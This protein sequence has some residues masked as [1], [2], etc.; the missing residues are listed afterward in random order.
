MPLIARSLYTDLHFSSSVS[1]YQVIQGK[2]SFIH[3]LPSSERASQADGINFS[4]GVTEAAEKNL[5]AAARSNWP[6]A[7]PLGLTPPGRGAVGAGGGLVALGTGGLPGTFG[8]VLGL[9]AT[10]GG[11]AGFFPTGGAGG[12]GLAPAVLDGREFTGVVP[13]EATGVFFHGAAVPLDGAMPGNTD[14]GFA[15]AF[16]VRDCTLILACCVGAAAGFGAT[17]GAVGGAGGRRVAGGG[18]SAAFGFGGTRSR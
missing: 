8:P 14:M 13:V 9:E 12:G 6:R 16:A 4:I 7:P 1:R 15:E 2:T 11:G 5:T 3:S 18:A 10:G 17:T